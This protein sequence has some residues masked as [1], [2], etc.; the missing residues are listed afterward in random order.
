[1]QRS[2]LRQAG[3]SEG[4]ITKLIS[5]YGSFDKIS[6]ANLDEVA[7]ITNK[8]VAAKLLTLK[9]GNLK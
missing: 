5:F 9:E 8:S 4:S 3:V 6:E 2:Q 7:K 1:M